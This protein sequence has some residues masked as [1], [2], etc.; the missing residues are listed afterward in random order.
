MAIID[1]QRNA[2]EDLLSFAGEFQINLWSLEDWTLELDS[3]PIIFCGISEG[4]GPHSHS[5]ATVAVFSFGS[6]GHSQPLPTRRCDAA[7]LLRSPTQS[8]RAKWGSNTALHSLDAIKIEITERGV[9][10]CKLGHST[11]YVPL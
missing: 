7:V 11:Q 3:E 4:H 10:V 1:T 6:A 8:E 9:R 2:I 5:D